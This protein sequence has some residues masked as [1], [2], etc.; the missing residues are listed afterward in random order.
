MRTSS[1]R[2][3][4]R[5]ILARMKAIALLLALALSSSAATLSPQW[6][7]DD[8]EL[9]TYFRKRTEA[10]AE[11][12]LANIKSARDWNQRVP[13][14][15]AQLGEML[16]LS[17]LPP[18]GDLHATI[19]GR[20]EQDE[21]T[22]EKL[23][24]QSLPNLYVTANLYIPKNL[25]RP[26]PT[27]LYVCGHSPVI[28]NGVS[29]GTKAAYQHHGIWFARNGYV[30]L[31]VDTLES[32]EILGQH[33]GTY[34]ENM[35]WWNSRG[36]TPAGVETW[37][38]MRALDYLSTRPEVDTNRFAITGRSGG[39]AQSWYITAMDERIRC[40]APVAG[41]TDLE[42]HV[43]D[44]AVEG[45]CDCMFFVNTYRWDYPQLAALAAPRPLLFCNTDADNI[46]PLDGVVRT[47]A[48]IRRIY[49]LL[50][51]KDDL[52]LVITPGPHKDTQ[53]LQLPV[54]RWFNQHLRNTNSL[55]E[56][57]AAKRFT[58][59]ELKVFKELPSDA[60]NTNIHFTFVPAA[61]A[62]IAQT[63]PQ[64]KAQRDALLASLREKC[65]AAWPEGESLPGLVGTSFAA[66][67]GNAYD[68]FK[69]HDA[70]ADWRLSCAWLSR[71]S[72]G[73][74]KR[75][76]IRVGVNASTSKPTPEE[77]IVTVSDPLEITKDAKKAIQLR[78]RFML[79]RETVDSKRVWQLTM[80]IRWLRSSPEFRFRKLPICVE[81][82]GAA[83]VNALYASLFAPVD[84][85]VLTRL[86]RSHMNGPDYLNVLRVLDVPQAVAMASERGVVELRD[87]SPSDWN[88]PI[89][90]ARR[91]GW[92][93]NLRIVSS[94]E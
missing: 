14:M 58:P 77:V 74:V 25:T 47:H 15:R 69:F 51:A 48:K 89:E 94:A 82:E 73:R 32:G 17:P 60:I 49:E 91:F 52:G 23:H 85:L 68:N 24:F 44:G 8:I 43:V 56:N 39:G 90:V 75:V 76:I 4:L 64:W 65:F 63:E 81:A 55:V 72:V 41:I 18:R 40:A 62:Q 84:E 86:P 80:A 45:H 50:G 61:T 88:V 34:R 30:C 37:N 67:G 13:E 3:P 66:V 1:T 12:C 31:I 57:A 71:F 33:H 11:H 6:N 28:T 19:T 79:M 29:Y 42:N 26:A 27:V 46:F 7:V 5:G 70:G 83:A 53:E 22:V 16:G 2:Q 78:R 35:W 87:V 10:I 21:F 59:Q 9:A 20:I 36:Y 92:E 54:M 38:G 93:K